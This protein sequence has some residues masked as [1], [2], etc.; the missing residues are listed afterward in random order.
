MSDRYRQDSSCKCVCVCACVFACMFL[1]RDFL[2]RHR[3]G[4]DR[5]RESSCPCCERVCI[6]FPPCLHA[7][8]PSNSSLAACRTFIVSWGRP[9]PWDNG[10]SFHDT[11]SHHECVLSLSLPLSHQSLSALSLTA[12]FSSSDA[13][14]SGFRSSHG[15]PAKQP[16]C[17]RCHAI[18]I[19]PI[20]HPCVALLATM[21]W[22][23]RLPPCVVVL[24]SGIP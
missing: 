18:P 15:P 10:R 1:V 17:A 24:L 20:A 19:K 21:P 16:P 3:A 11:Q 13:R 2:E 23:L 14:P 8:P 12:F 6:M 9:V 22:M 7:P 4:R 5:E